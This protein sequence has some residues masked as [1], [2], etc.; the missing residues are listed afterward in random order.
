[1]QKLEFDYEKAVKKEQNRLKKLF[2][3]IPENKMKLVEGLIVQAA[4]L[5]ASCD[6]LW[7]EIKT[8]GE[9]EDFQNGKDAEF[10]TRETA[11]SKTFTARDKSYLAVMK[12]LAEY[13]P[14]QVSVSKLTEFMN[15]NNDN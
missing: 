9:Y 10:I 3:D 2:K 11:A 4:R 13:L 7:L 15:M 12:Q 1:M 6:A 14:T 8:N 5:R